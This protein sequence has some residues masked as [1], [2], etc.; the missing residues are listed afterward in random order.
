METMESKTKKKPADS[1]ISAIEK[2]PWAITPEGLELILGIAQRDISD[3]EAALEKR[4]EYDKKLYQCNEDGIAIINIFGSIF[5]RAG[6]FGAISGGGSIESYS[7]GLTEALADDSVKAILFNIDSPGG[8]VTGV[9]EFANAIYNARGTKPIYAYI[10][11]MGA[12]AA[13]WIASAVDKIYGDATARIGCIGVVAAWSDSREMKKRAGVRDYQVVS[14]QTPNKNLDPTT[15]A[16][17]EEL[18]KDLDAFAEIFIENLARNR[19]VS[20]EYVRENFGKGSMLIANE[21]EYNRMIDGLSSLENVVKDLKNLTANSKNVSLLKIG[22]NAMSATKNE[23]SSNLEIKDNKKSS[24]KLE[25]NTVNAP[26]EETAG[27]GIEETPAASHFLNETKL[28]ASNP[29]LYNA[30]VQKGVMQ[31][32]QRIKEIDAMSAVIDNKALIEEAKFSKP[33]NAEQ[34]AFKVLQAEGKAGKS[35]AANFAS[36]KEEINGVTGSVNNGENS[37]KTAQFNA[38]VKAIVAGGKLA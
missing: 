12:S 9:H 30:I 8:Q 36:D 1:V 33:C 17:R 7:K 24:E 19:S 20:V 6:L 5:P 13:Y 32:R 15:D 28:L 3:F 38:D 37:D 25:Q 18:Q 16:G 22:E 35:F 29:E 27:G 11:G 2:T 14:S 26:L 34:L 21:A 31:E 4:Q 23:N 10:S